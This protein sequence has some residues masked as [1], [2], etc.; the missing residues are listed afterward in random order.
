MK[1]ILL[2]LLPVAALAGGIV[3]RTPAPAGAAGPLAAGLPNGKAVAQPVVTRPVMVKPVPV[4]IQAVGTVTPLAIV[5]VKA[6]IDS[7]I[8]EIHF[9]EGQEV[10]R[11]DL[12]FGLDQRPAELLLRQAEAGLARDRATLEKNRADV[13]RD[14]ELVK[15]DHIPRS[16]YEAA[17]AAAASMEATVKADAAQIDSARLTLDYGR[18]RAP[19][20]GRTGAIQVHAGNTVRA[21]DT[22]ALVTITQLRPITVAFSVPERELPGIRA[23]M[24]AGT[25]AVT[26]RGT[27]PA[28]GPGG[29]PVPSIDGV[30]SF[31]DSTVDPATGTILLK[32]S[33]PNADARLWPGMFVSATLTLR[34]DPAALVVP[35]E[36]VQTGQKGLYVFVVRDDATVEVRPVTVARA[37]G[38]ETVLADGVAAGERVVVDGQLRLAPG[39]RVVEAA[40]P[41]S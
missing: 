24:A 2:A 32:A 8:E 19:I 15:R 21:N 4:R 28:S 3:W 38:A 7:Q 37:L 13:A 34:T 26:V 25:P 1:R 5:Q 6:R 17:V 40:P 29:T 18:I 22:Q 10:R 23:A 12:L 41:R 27:A 14:A 11:G 30:L 20:D 39:A 36:A 31:I 35:T 9:A 16:Q 33:F